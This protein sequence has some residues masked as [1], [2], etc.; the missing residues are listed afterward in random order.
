V[1]KRRREIGESVSAPTTAARGCGGYQREGGRVARGG[2]VTNA[3]WGIRRVVR[4]YK[5]RI[6]N[7]GER[8]MS[9]AVSRLGETESR[10]KPKRG[11]R[12]EDQWTCAGVPRHHGDLLATSR[13]KMAT[14]P[15]RIAKRWRQSHVH[16]LC[17]SFNRDL[18][19]SD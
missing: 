2:G 9:P 7:P 14:S 19:D 13:N 3:R 8:D 4:G 16:L 17:I 11:Q 10:E 6:A 12:R 18:V 15:P 5:R 1:G